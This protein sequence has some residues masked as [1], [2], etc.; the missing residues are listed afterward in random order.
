MTLTINYQPST[1]SLNETDWGFS[2]NHAKTTLED[3]TTNY[4]GLSGPQQHS[5]HV[6]VCTDCN[7]WYN[8]LEQ[9]WEA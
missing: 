3:A 1:W 4:M 8:D 6:E 2:C 5:F 7:K 9:R